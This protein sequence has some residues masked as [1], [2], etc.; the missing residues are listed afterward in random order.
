MD[1]MKSY[2][3]LMALIAGWILL[4]GINSAN[5]HIG[6]LG[7]KSLR[8]PLQLAYFITKTFRTVA[9][10]FLAIATFIMVSRQQA[11]EKTKSASSGEM[12]R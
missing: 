3:L 9:L 6:S 12:D 11:A 5:G 8:K 10:F 2:K 7:A 4:V 1:F